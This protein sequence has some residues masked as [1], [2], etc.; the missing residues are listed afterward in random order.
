M[1]LD[2]IVLGG[3]MSLLLLAS[4]TWFYLLYMELSIYD[5]NAWLL[6]KLS[7]TSFLFTDVIQKI[8]LF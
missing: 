8:Y 1:D 7:T 6:A 5:G 2:I 4:I 3:D